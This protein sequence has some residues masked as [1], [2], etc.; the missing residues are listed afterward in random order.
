MVRF[1]DTHRQ[2]YGV[3]SS[4][5]L[6]PIAP[7]TYYKHGRERRFPELRAARTRSDERLASQIERI[8]LAS[9]QNYGAY[10]VWRQ[11]QREGHKVARCTVERLM[12]RRGWY[13]VTRRKSPRTTRAALATRRPE[14]LVKRAFKASGPE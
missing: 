6:L 10:K 11:L 2:D 8:W 5:K 4:C 12:A 1:I 13:G 9:D 3:E 14:D 7:S